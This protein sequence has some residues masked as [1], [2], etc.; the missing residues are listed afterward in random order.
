MLFFLDLARTRLP[1]AVG[2]WGGVSLYIYIYTCQEA[3]QANAEQSSSSAGRG[4][5]LPQ[6]VSP[7]P[8]WDP[9]TSESTS[10]QG[11][12]LPCSSQDAGQAVFARETPWSRRV[13]LRSESQALGPPVGETAV[14]RPMPSAKGELP[15]L[16]GWLAQTGA[17][18]SIEMLPKTLGFEWGVSGPSGMLLQWLTKGQDRAVYTANDLILKISTT[19]Q[20]HE[21]ELAKMLPGIA[22]KTYWAEDVELFLHG[23]NRELKGPVSLVCQER[24]VLATEVLE[25]RGQTFSFQ[26]MCHV[27]CILV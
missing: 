26:F 23:N 15:K 19:C 9:S 24:C 12:V 14:S 27:G 17:S 10:E 20:K 1:P 4:E 2:P 11:E 7:A 25:A 18:N 22:A 5:F 8:D 6:P 13:R 21:Y 16:H 3:G